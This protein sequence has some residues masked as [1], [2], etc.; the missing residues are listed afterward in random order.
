M[1]RYPMPVPFSGAKFASRYELS[2]LKGDFWSDG[3]FL[4]VP[5]NLPDDPPIF[6]A[7]DPPKPNVKTRLDAVKTLPELIA[8]LKEELS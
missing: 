3:E 6:E 8:L 4:Y 7:P 1:K 2:S 5:D